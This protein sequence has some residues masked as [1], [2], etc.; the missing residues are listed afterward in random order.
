M[1]KIREYMSKLKLWSSL[2]DSVISNPRACS[3]D[4]KESRSHSLAA[5]LKEA[6][7]ELL[8]GFCNGKAGTAQFLHPP[9][10]LPHQVNPFLNRKNKQNQPFYVFTVGKAIPLET[11]RPGVAVLLLPTEE[12]Q[13][14]S[15]AQFSS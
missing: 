1:H 8:L 4:G 13:Q 9:P 3:M 7:E 14:R 12:E 6:N 2:G 15:R 10:L 5:W 11:S